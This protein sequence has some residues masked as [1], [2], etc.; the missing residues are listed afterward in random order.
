MSESCRIVGLAL[1]HLICWLMRVQTISK[2]FTALHLNKRSLLF[3]VFTFLWILL[4]LCSLL[5]CMETPFTICL[6]CFPNPVSTCSLLSLFRWDQSPP[7]QSYQPPREPP[8]PLGGALSLCWRW[9]RG[10][11]WLWEAGG[12]KLLGA[13][14]A[15]R[16]SPESKDRDH[17][18]PWTLQSW[19]WL[20]PE[21]PG[22]HQP[23]THTH[24]ARPRHHNLPRASLSQ[25]GQQQ[26]LCVVAF[27][28]LLTLR[29]TL[30]VPQQRTGGE[31]GAVPSPPKH[32]HRLSTH[33]SRHLTPH[34]PGWR[35]LPGPFPF[36]QAWLSLHLPPGQAHLRHVQKSQPGT[37]GSFTQPL[38]PWQPWQPPPH[39]P[40][41]FQQPTRGHKWV[42]TTWFSSHQDSQNQPAALHSL[43]RPS[44]RELPGVMWSRYQDQTRALLCHSFHLAQ[45][46]GAWN[47]QVDVRPAH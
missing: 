25:S 18:V 31:W 47:L 19:P 14:Q 23:K 30:C 46:I 13:H 27:W 10:C 9:L 33:Q 39:Q 21:P 8:V 15:S 2:A 42:W 43:P 16:A 3:L 26:L 29:F 4:F 6:I 34:Q 11:I 5:Y 17:P 12:E 32:P 37:W 38:A 22:E 36:P 45:A 40:L 1:Y 7:T 20:P 44:F 24:C 41:Q 35:R 28:D